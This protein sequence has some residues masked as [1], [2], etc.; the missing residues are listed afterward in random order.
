[1]VMPAGMPPA[2]PPGALPLFSGFSVMTAWVV[3]II[4]AME[5]ALDSPLRVT[6]VGSRTPYSIRFSTRSYIAL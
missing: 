6:L 5:A 2:M 3:S 4:P 1:M